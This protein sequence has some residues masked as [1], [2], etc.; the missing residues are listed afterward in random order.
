MCMGL[1]ALFYF[2]DYG[3]RCRG[4]SMMADVKNILHLGDNGRNVPVVEKDWMT[5]SKRLWYTFVRPEKRE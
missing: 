3:T 5:S 2:I 1:G 4:V